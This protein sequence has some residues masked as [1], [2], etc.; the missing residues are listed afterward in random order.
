MWI[1]EIYINKVSINNK[2]MS[3]KSQSLEPGE[4]VTIKLAY[5]S[6]IS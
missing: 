2:F 4:Y 1:Y 6:S 3:H 5:G